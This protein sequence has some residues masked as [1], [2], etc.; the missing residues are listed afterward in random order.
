MAVGMYTSRESRGLPVVC[1][2]DPLHIAVGVVYTDSALGNSIWAGIEAQ[3]VGCKL[4]WDSSRDVQQQHIR[5]AIVE[6][7][8]H[9]LQAARRQG[10]SV[11]C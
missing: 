2:G 8:F 9:T 5:L 11:P 4:V 1:I 7:Q 6:H 3:Q 10:S